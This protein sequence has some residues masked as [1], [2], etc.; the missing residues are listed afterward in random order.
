MSARCISS[1]RLVIRY[2]CCGR[3]CPVTKHVAK[4]PTLIAHRAYI[5]VPHSRPLRTEAALLFQHLLFLGL[6]VSVDLCAFG[7]LVAVI[8][9]LYNNI[10]RGTACRKGGR[11]TG[12]VGSFW[13]SA[14]SLEIGSGSCWRCE[15][16]SFEL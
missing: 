12:R 8:L 2:C 7:R 11:H 16:V 10:K 13:D 3:L 9:G 5:Y 1:L 14:A 4:T 6:D 15:L